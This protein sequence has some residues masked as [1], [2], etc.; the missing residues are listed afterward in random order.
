MLR[1]Q[2]LKPIF[3]SLLFSLVTIMCHAQAQTISGKVTDEKGEVLP[4]VS[5]N[6]KGATAS[7]GTDASGS[8]IINTTSA[9]PVLVFTMIGYKRQEIAVGNATKLNVVLSDESQTLSE[10]VVVGYGTQ[11]R[12]DVTGSVVSV[13]GD[14]FR[15]QPIT[16]VTEALAGRAAGVNVAKGSGAPDAA[17]SIIIRGLSSLNQPQPL[18]IVDGIRMAGEQNVNPQDIASIDV[19]KDAS[20]AAI[21]GSAAAGGVIVITTKKGKI[22]APTINFN[23]RYGITKPRVVGLLNKDE[24][25]SLQNIINPTF[26]AGATKLDTLANS[27]WVDALYSDANEQNYNLSITGASPVV[28]YL[29]SGFYN[30]Q[31]G[32]YLRNYSN[33]GGA[34]INTD[35]VLGKRIKI[36]QQLSLSQRKTAPPIGSEAQLHNAPFRTIPIM[37]IYNADGSYGSA[38]TGYGTLKFGGV[39]PVG[40]AN[41]ADVEDF[42]NNLQA[43]VY[44]EAKLPL[45]LTF[46]TNFGYSYYNQSQDYFQNSFSFGQ[47]SNAA[48]SLTKQSVIS[49]QLVS[50][51]VLS[52]DKSFGSHA[53]NAVAGYEQ[54]NG[55]Y[56]ALNVRASQIG[57]PGY[58]FVP[59]SETEYVVNGQTDNNALVKSIFGRVNY[60]F[61]G[62]YYLSGSIREDA[63]FTVFGPNK[64]RGIFPSVSAG[65]NISEEKFFKT[66]APTVNVLKLRGSYGELGNSNIGAYNFLA[67]YSNFTAGGNGSAGGQ[68]FAPGAKPVLG[69]SFGA[70]P[71]PDLRWETV[72]E[73]NIGLDGEMLDN[74]LYFTVEW[75]KKKT[76]DMLY[77]LPLSL[78][79]GITTPYLTNIGEVDSKGI[80]LLLGYRSKAGN[81]G[82]DISFNAGFNKNNVVKLS[83]VISSSISDGYNFYNNGDRGFNIMSNQTLTIT[84]AGSPFG[85]FYGYKVLGMFKTDAEAAASPQ[86]ATALAGD[87]IYQDLDNSGTITEGDKQIIGNPNPKMVYGANIRVNFK[88][89]DAALLFNGVAG[90]DIFNGKKAYEM[91]PFQDGTTSPKVFGASF[92]GANQLTDQPRLGVANANGT[93][94]LDPNK[95]YQSVNSYFVE[96]GD[97]LKLRN[98]QIGYTFSSS[99]LQRVKV[100][101]ARLFVMANNVFTITK[102]S[103]LDPELS[104]AFSVAGYTGPTTRGIDAV[105]S[106]PQTRIYSLGLDLNF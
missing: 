34:R 24:Y 84:K 88:G 67:L 59:T 7:A 90:V 69:V 106:Y 86:K 39:N 91:F 72:K 64:Q 65:W 54:I 25:I 4:G 98:L 75:Y 31:E 85:S 1:Q 82:Y 101:N 81:V 78:S 53:L 97:Y 104:S 100:K 8:Y 6:E 50:N 45:Y 23:S 42:K 35:Y 76:E 48:N 18:Y 80:D 51:F 60:N 73:S 56:N 99:A 26:F 61:G 40:A 11:R 62:R 33:I 46:R 70:I 38:P 36:G 105:T 30:K 74:K 47:V 19:L 3:L 103:G 32:V 41:K 17:P 68:N 2:L 43:N 96:K 77:S 87:L 44:G 27:D 93:Y 10:V 49:S 16:N 63:N 102:Y 5:V 12:K 79:S 29:F 14:A 89:F 22:G 92:L 21:Y 15:N 58:S 55:K 20:S 57:L 13:K 9:K 83:D 66:I 71:N 28:N 95:N 94:T 37:P 52:F